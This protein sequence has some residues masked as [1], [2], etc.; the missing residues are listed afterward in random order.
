MKPVSVLALILVLAGC[1]STGGTQP[2][3]APDPEPEPMTASHPDI[4]WA[5]DAEANPHE[6]RWRCA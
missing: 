6:Y 5:L 2:E 3:P 1:N 4:E